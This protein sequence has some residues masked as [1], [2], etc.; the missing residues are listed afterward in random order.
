MY[1]DA[2]HAAIRAT[3][4]NL[5]YRL[6]PDDMAV[7]DDEM[8]LIRARLSAES[9]V[10]EDEVMQ[11][12]VGVHMFSDLYQGE[13]E[14]HK[15]DPDAVPMDELRKT[16]QRVRDAMDLMQIT[17]RKRLAATD[18]LFPEL[19]WPKRKPSKPPPKK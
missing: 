4:R 19:H 9:Q 10:D 2:L 16:E 13:Y 18:R 3:L 5:G 8:N 12:L 7:P 11:G 15:A 6:G 1:T 14:H 17:I